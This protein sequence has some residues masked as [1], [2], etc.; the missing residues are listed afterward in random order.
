MVDDGRSWKEVFSF[1][2]HVML[3]KE[4][5]ERA[6]EIDPAAPPI[7]RKGGAPRRAHA[8]PPV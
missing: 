7:R 5:A 2:E 8:R 4:E 6:R 1:C 3:Q